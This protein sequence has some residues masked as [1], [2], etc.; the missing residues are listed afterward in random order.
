MNN[1][2]RIGIISALCM[3]ALALCSVGSYAFE[4]VREAVTWAFGAMVQTFRPFGELFAVDLST[5][6]SP[7]AYAGP[8]PHYLRHEAGMNHRAAARHV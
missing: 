6:R 3:A 4:R 8:S 1:R 5:L 7:L 2:F